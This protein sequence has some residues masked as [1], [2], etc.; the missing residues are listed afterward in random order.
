MIGMGDKIVD[1]DTY[2]PSLNYIMLWFTHFQHDLS[3]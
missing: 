1:I 3:L 2:D